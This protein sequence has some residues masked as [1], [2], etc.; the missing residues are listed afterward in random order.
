M[1]A[2]D[3]KRWQD[4]EK[5]AQKHQLAFSVNREHWGETVIR[6]ASTFR[7]IIR[8]QPTTRDTAFVSLYFRTSS[9]DFDG[10]R[11]DWHDIV[12]VLLA[13]YLRSVAS[14]SCRLWDQH[15]PAVPLPAELY[16][17][18]L[19]L[20][21]PD[22][23]LIKLDKA[24]LA[25]VDKL[26]TH[27]KLFEMMFSGW[28]DW[29]H[30]EGQCDS[31]SSYAEAKEWAARVRTATRDGSNTNVT[32]ANVRWHPDWKY[33]RS[34][35]T[36]FSIVEAARTA[37][38]V[39]GLARMLEPERIQEKGG[40]FLVSGRLR[41]FVSKYHTQRIRRVLKE[42]SGQ[43][44][45]VPMIVLENALVGVSQRFIAVYQCECGFQAFKKAR[46]SIWPRHE[47]EARLLFPP[48]V[49][50]W[51]KVI[52][53]G[54]FESLILE[55]VRREPGVIR[56]H[57]TGSSRDRDQSRD[58]MIDWR[59]P[60]LEDTTGLEPEEQM[61]F[62]LRRVVGQCKASSRPVGKAAVPDIRDTVEHHGATGFFLATASHLT[63]D[64]VS[65]LDSLQQDR[66]IL[67]RWWTRADIEERL[68]SNPDICIRYSS[69]V[70]ANNTTGVDNERS[71]VSC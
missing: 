47:L 71:G 39:E 8:F 22:G 36:R 69:I 21:Q 60:K 45:D 66:G 44:D 27:I 40:V 2:M 38:V 9:W 31:R 15:N 61:L 63:N 50:E 1:T 53:D 67:T 10:D 6:L 62:E 5:L 46:E 43:G 34:A 68:R 57:R 35:K 30:E 23:S 16:G 3:D 64:L 54:E 49:F 32:T 13:C 70:R 14:L 51:A 48:T 17:R 12:S 41:H 18:Y 29:S 65:H 37:T 52:D 7:T 26:L 56:A 25:A 55:L 58:L 28:F 19:T 4:L 59:V 24:G 42:L 20:D 33:F 11:T